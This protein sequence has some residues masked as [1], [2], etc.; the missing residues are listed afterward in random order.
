MF[1]IGQRIEHWLAEGHRALAHHGVPELQRHAMVADANVAAVGLLEQV[2]DVDGDD[3]DH[4]RFERLAIAD[5]HAVA[6]RLLRPILVA[7]ALTRGVAREHRGEILDLG[8][9]VALDIVAALS[10]RM[11]RADVVPGA[12]AARLAASVMKVPADAALAPVGAT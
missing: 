3:L 11:R 7:P 9:E 12:I 1:G 4:L 6:H 8:A 2:R 5:H 10:H